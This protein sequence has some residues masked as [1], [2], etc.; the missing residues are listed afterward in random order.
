MVINNFTFLQNCHH[1][2]GLITFGENEK[3]WKEQGCQQSWIYKTLTSQL[4]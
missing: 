3:A 2:E 4:G 1:T